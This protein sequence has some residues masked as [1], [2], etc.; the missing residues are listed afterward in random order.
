MEIVQKFALNTPPQSV[1]TFL[2][3]P[4]QVA[5]CLPGATI[6]E[7]IDDRTYTGTMTVKIGPVLANY[8]GKIRFERLD[9]KTQ[10][11][12]IVAQ[13]QEV[14]GKGS[15]EMRML[16]HLSPLEDGGTEVTV[17][18]QVKIIGLLAQFGRGMIS[19]VADQIF[20]QF[21]ARLKGTLE[22]GTPVAPGS[23][24]AKP[25]NALSL[26]SRAIGHAVGRMIRRLFGFSRP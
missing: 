3:D 23:A 26:G 6:T 2:T 7:K 15:A 12:E 25:V 14:K 19:D 18:S 13:G 20:Q 8:K 16:T 21:A 9:P 11:A 22:A 24:T 4:Y 10:E 5:S 1:W 17:L